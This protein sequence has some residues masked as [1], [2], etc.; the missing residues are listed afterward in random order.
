MSFAIPDNQSSPQRRH[1]LPG[2]APRYDERTR[3]SICQRALDGDMLFLDET[4]DVPEPRQ[5]WIFCQEC[6]A[7]VR[8][9]MERSPVEGPLR[10]RIAVGLVA[11]E[12]SP[13]AI[14]RT[15]AGLSDDGWLR[16]MFWVFGLGVLLHL[17]VIAWIAYLIR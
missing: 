14:R 10:A 8:A 12:R 1:S 13:Y 15:R 3:C 2:L 17:I 6:D 5:S 16:F 7:A 11:S 9:E 4:G